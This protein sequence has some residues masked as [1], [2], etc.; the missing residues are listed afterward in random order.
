VFIEKFCFI[1]YKG[2][3]MSSWRLWIWCF[4]SQPPQDLLYP[5]WWRRSRHGTHWSV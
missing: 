3:Y 5:P 4:P 2:W 1:Q